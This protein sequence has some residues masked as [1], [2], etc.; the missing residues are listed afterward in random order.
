[1]QVEHIGRSKLVLA[2]KWLSDRHDKALLR[3]TLAEESLK[4]IGKHTVE[5]LLSEF[6]KQ[7]AYQSRPTPRKYIF[8]LFILLPLIFVKASPSFRL[9]E[10]SSKSLL[11]RLQLMRSRSNLPS[12]TDG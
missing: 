10:L 4:V 5:D 3:L 8:S 1:L 9:S 12:S 6:S 11:P 7:R 2:G